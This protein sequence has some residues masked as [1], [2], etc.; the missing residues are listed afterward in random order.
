M[1]VTYLVL[2]QFITL[3]TVLPFITRATYLCVNER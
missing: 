2:L 1:R 3:E